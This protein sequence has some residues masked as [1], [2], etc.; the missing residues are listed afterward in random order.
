MEPATVHGRP[1]R[2]VPQL[3]LVPEMV[4]PFAQLHCEAHW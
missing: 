4:P 3:V 2:L 1:C